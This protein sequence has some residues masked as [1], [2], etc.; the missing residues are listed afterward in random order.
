MSAPCNDLREDLSLYIDSELDQNQKAKLADHLNSCVGCKAYINNLTSMRQLFNQAKEN[1]GKD[2]DIWQSLS[3]KLPSVC[4]GIQED[5]SAYLD[6]ELTPP[7]Q[8]GISNHLQ[9]CDPCLNAFQSLTKVNNLL[10]QGLKLPE[11]QSIDIWSKV[12]SRINEDCVLIKDELSA[13]IDKEVT[14]LRHRTITAHL[15]TCSNCRQRFTLLSNTSELL[16]NSYQANFPDN[17]DLWPELQRK[18]KVIPFAA[19][20]KK[21]TLKNN[22]FYVAAAGVALGLLASVIFFAKTQSI[23]NIEPVSA[24][25]YLIESTLGEPASGVE[26]VVYEYP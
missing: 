20:E 11:S 21:S 6:G 13:Y 5:L 22:R 3:T 18:M 16:R 12:K 24:E 8:E 14:T 7:A 19:R 4:D 26:S 10:S 17:F 23:S 25:A 9:K 2:I 15:L 1:S